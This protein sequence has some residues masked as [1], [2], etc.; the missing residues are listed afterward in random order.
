M[1]LLL[2][3]EFGKLYGVPLDEVP[4]DGQ[5]HKKF[6]IAFLTCREILIRDRIG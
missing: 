1:E 2:W 5:V 4:I 3:R 6:M